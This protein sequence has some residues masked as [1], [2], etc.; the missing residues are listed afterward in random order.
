MVHGF[1]RKKE[2]YSAAA[3]AELIHVHYKGLEFNII[4]T[5]SMLMYE[6]SLK[7]MMALCKI[8]IMYIF[9]LKSNTFF[10]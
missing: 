1:V 2:Y 9:K 7:P 6:V 8:N 5:M 10:F 3:A 4:Y